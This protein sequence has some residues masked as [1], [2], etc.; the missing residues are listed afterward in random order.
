MSEERYPADLKVTAEHFAKSGWKQAIDGAR[1]E[2]YSAMWSALSGAARQAMA[3]EK[4]A[5]GKVLWLLADACSMTLRPERSNN[6]FDPFFV[7]EGRRSGLPEDFAEE[8]IAFFAEIV[9]QADDAWLRGRLADLVWLCS[10][11]RDPK[12]ALIAIDA[13]RELELDTETWIRGGRECWERAIRLALMLRDGSGVRLA[14]MRD[15]LLA[16][17]NG[18]TV[19]DG[20]LGLWLADLLEDHRLVSDHPNEVAGHLERLAKD[21]DAADDLHRCRDYFNRA[22]R[23]FKKAGDEAKAAENTIAEAEGWVK[24]ARARV[25]G[26]SPSHMAAATFY[27]NAIQVYRTIPRSER[28]VYCVEERLDELRRC[29]SDAG[30]RSIGEMGE[31]RSPGVDISELVENSRKAVRGK[32]PVEALKALCNLHAGYNIG[33]ARE[34]ALERIRQ[35]P[36]QSL[37]PAAVMSPDGRVIAKRPGASLSAGDSGDDEV[38]VRTE[39]IRDYGLWVGIV[40]QGDIWPGLETLRLEHRLH[41]ADFVNL[42][43]QSPIVP[44]DRAR[45][46]GKALFA[47]YEG[48]FVAAIHLLTPQI[49]HMVRHHLKIAGV[50][51][52]SLDKN[53]IEHEIGLSSLIEIPEVKKIFGEDLA[54]E[55]DA[56]LCNSFGPNLR[57]EIAHGLLDD[58]SCESI[59]AIYAWWLG[60]RLTFNTFWNAIH[61]ESQDSEEGG[62]S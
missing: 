8:D 41:E 50:K 57:N 43:G 40:V 60:L 10:K 31:V 22:V 46:F 62:E 55:F 32:S 19:D 45:L 58:Q 48:D 35:H 27:E 56:L 18:T 17:F 1:R 30:E 28:A 44:K 13:Y 14:E 39:L 29:L 21:F 52:T 51:T 12:Y 6:P 26:E 49:E 7:M 24:E 59:Y 9:E 54:F 5:E 2:G 3:D 16:A 11:P 61:R 42:C 53:G 33:S 15:T 47:G 4:L 20:Y 25:S 37:F 23:W 38:V 36:I 34:N